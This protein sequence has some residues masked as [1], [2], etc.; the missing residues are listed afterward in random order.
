MFFKKRKHRK[1]S[2]V[3]PASTEQPQAV[4]QEVEQLNFEKPTCKQVAEPQP[5]VSNDDNEALEPTISDQELAEFMDTSNQELESAADEFVKHMVNSGNDRALIHR[6]LDSSRFGYER[7][8]V[9]QG[10]LEMMK[11]PFS[12]EM[13]MPPVTFAGA[14]MPGES[15]AGMELT[16]PQSNL[17]L[18]GNVRN[19][20]FS[21]A[22]LTHA[23]FSQATIESLA[24]IGC[25]AEGLKIN[26]DS[27]SSII[28]GYTFVSMD[29]EE[30]KVVTYIFNAEN[31][32]ELQKKFSIPAEIIEN[33]KSHR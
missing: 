24:L 1:D 28:P 20:V 3:A 16:G 10:L 17:K 2:V 21:M 15:L 19:L 7:E 18:L 25:D 5:A 11:N 26:F 14:Q 29:G 33:I 8:K 9:F 12:G 30:H 22:D 27:V 13:M 6:V 23:D 32:P 4:P 31:S